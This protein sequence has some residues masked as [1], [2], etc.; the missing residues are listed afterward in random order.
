MQTYSFI[1]NP[2]SSYSFYRDPTGGFGF[3]QSF[4]SPVTAFYYTAVFGTFKDVFASFSFVDGQT[5]RFT[6]STYG[7]VPPMLSS[8]SSGSGGSDGALDS[9]INQTTSAVQ[10]VNS[11]IQSMTSVI[12]SEIS[13]LSSQ[14][15]QMTQAIQQSMQQMV[16]QLEQQTNTLSQI[17]TN[18]IQSIRQDLGLVNDNLSSGFSSVTTSITN[19][20]TQVTSKI[21]SLEQNVTTKLDNVNQSISDGFDQTSERLDTANDYLEDMPNQMGNKITELMVPSADDLVNQYEPFRQLLEEKLGVIYQI[22]AMI[23]ELI[24]TIANATVDQQTTITLPAFSLPWIDG[25]SLTLWESITFDVIPEGMELLSDGVK[26][27]TSFACV[28]NMFNAILRRYNEF[29]EASR[30]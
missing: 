22:P 28:A 12:S 24:G 21:D 17:I 8:D 19:Q 4:N 23:F 30:K 16:Q 20:T 9:A 18:Q 6:Y 27:F 7:T 5:Y 10:Q 2:V 11:S 13:A 25:S 15:G 3:Y 14:M 1:H 29:L 26:T